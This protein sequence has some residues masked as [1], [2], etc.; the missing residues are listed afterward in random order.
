MRTACG[1][2]C[3]VRCARGAAMR[4]LPVCACI[5]SLALSLLQPTAGSVGLTGDCQSAVGGETR[6]RKE[7]RTRDSIA[8]SGRF[9][10]PH[11]APEAGALSPELRG[12]RPDGTV[13][14]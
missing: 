5:R 8:P 14:P 4:L 2:C 13:T 12:L 1:R 10:R 9:E 11:P 7:P 3:R 6:G